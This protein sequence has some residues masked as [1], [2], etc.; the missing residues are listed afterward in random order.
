MVRLLV[1]GS[2]LSFCG[3]ERSD[4]LRRLRPVKTGVEDIPLVRK[5]A[6]AKIPQMT[7]AALSL[8]VDYS[9]REFCPGKLKL[10]GFV[11]LK[12]LSCWTRLHQSTGQFLLV[13]RIWRRHT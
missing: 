10:A 3:S 2:F 8:D 7:P 11:W 1:S 12:R 13:T 9:T 5:A 4:G 6:V